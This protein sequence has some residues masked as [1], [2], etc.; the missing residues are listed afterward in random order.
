MR[1]KFAEDIMELLRESQFLSESIFNAEL[2]VQRLV[3]LLDEI[4]KL[5]EEN[6]LLRDQVGASLIHVDINSPRG[7]LSSLISSG[8][9]ETQDVDGFG[10]AFDAESWLKVSQRSSLS[11]YIPVK[12]NWSKENKKKK[13]MIFQFPDADV[14]RVG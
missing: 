4:N 14:D 2:D 12:R 3:N 11:V 6:S 8:F 13:K 10:D 5:K 7:F 9:Q 1:N